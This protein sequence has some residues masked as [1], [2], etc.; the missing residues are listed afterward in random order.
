MNFGLEMSKSISKSKEDPDKTAA[1]RDKG[2]K[3]PDALDADPTMHVRAAARQFGVARSSLK[4]WRA[5]PIPFVGEKRSALLTPEG[6][7]GLVEHLRALSRIG[8]PASRAQIKLDVEDLLRR[9]EKL[10]EAD[11]IDGHWMTRF[12]ARYQD[13]SAGKK[14]QMSIAG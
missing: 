8:H 12:L 7:R 6:E 4:R 14:P 10:E 9:Q 5:N 2:R 1:K 13:E 11:S 3:A